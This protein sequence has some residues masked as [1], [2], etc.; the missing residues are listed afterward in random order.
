[1]DFMYILSQF[2]KTYRQFEEKKIRSSV[3]FLSI[4]AVPFVFVFDSAFII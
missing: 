3:S 1:M 2:I 4:P